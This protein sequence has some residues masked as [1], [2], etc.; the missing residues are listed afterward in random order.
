[1]KE[2]NYSRERDDDQEDSEAEEALSLC[3]LVLGDDHKNTSDIKEANIQ[4][5]SKFEFYTHLNTQTMRAAEDIMFHGKL[6]PYRPPPLLP[7]SGNHHRKSDSLS[8]L[9]APPK[10]RFTD[11][12]TKLR[13]DASAR[14]VRA[15]SMPQPNNRGYADKC[16]GKCDNSIKTAKPKWRLLMFGSLRTPTEMELKDIR[17]RQNRRIPTTWFP[18]GEEQKMSPDKRDEQKGSWRLLRAL[19]CKGETNGVITEALGCIRQV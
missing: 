2:D 3:D 17:N 14:M 6:L 15:K 8:Q 4:I 9:Q 1:M 5:S 16:F 10:V 19:S 11:D 18:S 7:A 13:R 12:Y